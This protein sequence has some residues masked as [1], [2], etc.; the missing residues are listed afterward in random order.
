MKKLLKNSCGEN[1]L[2]SIHQCFDRI[3]STTVLDL[4]VKCILYIKKEKIISV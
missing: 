2:T 1:W 3:E 4:K